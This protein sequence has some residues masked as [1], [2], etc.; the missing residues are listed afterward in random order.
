MLEEQQQHVPYQPYNGPARRRPQLP[1]EHPPEK[2][3]YSEIQD[4]ISRFAESEALS[5]LVFY[6]LN[7]FQSRKEN[8]RGFFLPS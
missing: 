3:S 1:R 5:K 8:R 4:Q 6:S 7:V 2:D